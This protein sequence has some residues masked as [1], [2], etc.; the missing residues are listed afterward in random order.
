MTPGGW[1]DSDAVVDAA[2]RAA[3]L[4]LLRVRLRV[5]YSP[6]EAAQRIR[7]AIGTAGVEAPPG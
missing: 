3:G 2:P 4:R 6:V 5:A 1:G 7:D